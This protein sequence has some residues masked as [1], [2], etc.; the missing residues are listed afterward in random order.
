MLKL[1]IPLLL[2]WPFIKWAIAVRYPQVLKRFE[3]RRAL[4]ML[5]EEWGQ[6]KEDARLK[7]I[8]R[9]FTQASKERAVIKALPGKLVNAVALP[10]RRIFVWQGL[11]DLVGDDEDMLAGVVAHELGHLSG[12]HYLQTVRDLTIA[13]FALGMFGGGWFRSMVQNL[14]M[15]IVSAGFSREQEEEADQAAVGFM[16]QAGF[17]PEGLARLFEALPRGGSQHIGLLGTH[18]APRARASRVR[19]LS[20]GFGG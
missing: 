20:E 7:R 16:V 5:V 9:R 19:R 13:R 12:E 14:A 10:D 2:A 4:R 1:L 18:P 3:G 8:G 15:R 17:D 11:L 6:P